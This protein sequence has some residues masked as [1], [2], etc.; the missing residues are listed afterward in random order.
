LRDTDNGPSKP[1][2]AGSSPAGRAI[3]GQVSRIR[4]SCRQ[5]ASINGAEPRPV[6]TYQLK[7]S[8]RF[9]ASSG[10]RRSS[11][12]HRSLFASHVPRMDGIVTTNGSRVVVGDPVSAERD[13][14]TP[15]SLAGGVRRRAWR[16]GRDI[17]HLGCGPTDG[18][19]RRRSPWSVWCRRDSPPTRRLVRGRGGNSVSLSRWTPRR[20]QELF[21][22]PPCSWVLGY[23]PEITICES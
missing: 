3:S 23:R 12:A 5:T 9:P 11:P 8:R 4:R 10:G 21:R 7:Y 19:S 1:G 17:P 18:A 6:A 22:I 13:P 16:R 15:Q 14:Y 20:I 2:V